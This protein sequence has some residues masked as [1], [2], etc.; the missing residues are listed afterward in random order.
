MHQRLDSTHTDCS[1]FTVTLLLRE[2]LALTD[3]PVGWAVQACR[4][5]RIPWR[6]VWETI[7]DLRTGQVSLRWCHMADAEACT[8]AIP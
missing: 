8:A 5:G 1:A 2:G 4:D 7:N 3:A 6:V